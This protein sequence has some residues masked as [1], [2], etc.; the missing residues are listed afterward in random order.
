LT[1]KHWTVEE[2]KRLRELVEDGCSV[3]EVSEKLGRSPEAI[4]SKVKRLGLDDD[5]QRR[6]TGLLSSRLELPEDLP[7]VEEQLRLLAAAISQLDTPGL[8]KA[9]VLRLRSIIVGVKSYK[10]LFT[11]YVDYRGIES[12]FEEAMVWLRKLGKERKSVERNKN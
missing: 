5:K 7:S 8:D 12:K 10:E 2:E 1:G 3:N 4:R 9:E 11:D 6:S